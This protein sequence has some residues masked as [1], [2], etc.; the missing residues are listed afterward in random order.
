M[1]SF[2]SFPSASLETGRSTSIYIYFQLMHRQRLNTFEP[3]PMKSW[4]DLDIKCNP[5]YRRWQPNFQ[6]SITLMRKPP[7]SPLYWE[8]NIGG[9]ALLNSGKLCNIET[10]WST[11]VF[12]NATNR[13]Y[14][15]WFTSKVQTH[16]LNSEADWNNQKRFS[17]ERKA[18]NG[19]RANFSAFPRIPPLHIL[20]T[21]WKW[22]KLLL[23]ALV[24]GNHHFGLGM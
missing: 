24:V 6:I 14:V 4:C 9:G 22:C 7:P 11:S 1:L 21:N 8:F 13:V 19:G 5:L 16:E 12:I 20:V 18:G 23:K 2:T 15:Y 17:P 10:L 3:R